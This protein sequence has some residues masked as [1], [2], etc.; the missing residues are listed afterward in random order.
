M[1][2]GCR[3]IVLYIEFSGSLLR[4]P[5]GKTIRTIIPLDNTKVWNPKDSIL[6]PCRGVDVCLLARG[7]Q[8]P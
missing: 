7:K 6:V 8:P 1:E 4:E 2:A 5:A 3:G